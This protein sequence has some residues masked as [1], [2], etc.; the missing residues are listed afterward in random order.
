[1]NDTV[2][3]LALLAMAGWFLAMAGW[4]AYTLWRII[5]K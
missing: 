3:R 1:M 2:S 4:F 5:H